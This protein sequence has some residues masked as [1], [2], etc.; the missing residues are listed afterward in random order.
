MDL[1]AGGQHALAAAALGGVPRLLGGP[2]AHHVPVGVGLGSYPIVIP[3]RGRI[4]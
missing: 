3:L 4:K 1:D 2:F